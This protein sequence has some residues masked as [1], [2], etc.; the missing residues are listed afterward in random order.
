MC[1]MC[2]YFEGVSRETIKGYCLE[3][4]EACLER[5]LGIYRVQK[6]KLDPS[7]SKQDTTSLV[8]N[9]CRVSARIRGSRSDIMAGAPSLA[10]GLS[11]I[12][13]GLDLS[14]GLVVTDRGLGVFIVTVIG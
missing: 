7:Y 11:V 6:P 5:E 1:A 13:G 12:I 9:L 14:F 10:G 8:T 4:N 2:I 3:G